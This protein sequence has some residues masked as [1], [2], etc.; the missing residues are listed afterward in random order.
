MSALP[1]KS[2]HAALLNALFE[3]QHAMAYAMR[4]SV[5]AEAEAV[6]VDYERVERLQQA[7][8]EAL[9]HELER[10]SLKP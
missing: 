1:V 8:I 3:M 6:I 2:K 4:R 7:R 9:E 10:A 5:L